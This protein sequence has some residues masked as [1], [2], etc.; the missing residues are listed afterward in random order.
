MIDDVLGKKDWTNWIPGAYK[1]S[2]KPSKK[3]MIDNFHRDLTLGNIELKRL[4]C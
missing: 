3:Q 4:L 2:K 1:K